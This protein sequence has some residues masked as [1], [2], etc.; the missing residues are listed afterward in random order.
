MSDTQAQTFAIHRKWIPIDEIH[1]YYP[2]I[3]CHLNFSIKILLD[4]ER[5][6][7]ISSYRN[8]FTMAYKTKYIIT[9]Y[10]GPK[11]KSYQK[12]TMLKNRMCALPQ[13][14][15]NSIDLFSCIW[16]C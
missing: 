14:N 3:H 13:K 6:D 11:F 7:N 16:T 9:K 5:P 1:V 4:S 15:Q 8:F 12:S 10:N 2:Y